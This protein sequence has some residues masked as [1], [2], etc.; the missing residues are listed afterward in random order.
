MKDLDR[1][2][3]QWQRERERKKGK[4]AEGAADV[5]SDIA[6]EF[7]EFLEMGAG[8]GA[9]RPAPLALRAAA[10]VEALPPMPIPHRPPCL[11]AHA[12]CPCRRRPCSAGAC[13]FKL[14]VQRG[15]GSLSDGRKSG[16][17][18]S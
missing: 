4:R 10:A 14:S 2:L 13:T 5:L 3:E 7:L 11:W 18:Q 12:T 1:E 16:L 9:A 15:P 6:E 17:N 8:L